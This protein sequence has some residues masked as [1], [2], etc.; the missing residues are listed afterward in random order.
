[1]T[2]SGR[3]VW[4]VVKRPLLNRDL[5]FRSGLTTNL[6]NFTNQKSKGPE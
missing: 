2:S 1:M 5:G 4:R 6:T 3:F